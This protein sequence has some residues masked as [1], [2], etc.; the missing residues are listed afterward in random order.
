MQL[1]CLQFPGG[2]FS[3]FVEAIAVLAE[4]APGLLSLHLHIKAAPSQMF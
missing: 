1:I 3:S 4:P 2:E